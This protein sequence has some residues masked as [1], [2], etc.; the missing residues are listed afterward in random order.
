MQALL[1]WQPPLPSVCVDQ[2]SLDYADLLYY[3]L[4]TSMRMF[5]AIIVSLCFT[6]SFATLAAKNRRAE[7]ILIPMLDVLQSVPVLGFLSFTLTFFFGLFPASV[8]GA[9]CASVFAIFASQAWNM[10]FS[11]YQSLR[12]VPQDLDEVAR[13]LHL[14]A[15]QRFWKLET[16]FA[17]PALIWNTMMSMSGGWFFVVASEAISVGDTTIKL[18]DIDLYF[19]VAI[20]EKRVDAVSAAVVMMLL[21]IILHDQ[22]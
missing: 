11:F 13:A 15:W 21:V 10:A 18:P 16:P 7:M 12:T 2:L 6:F 1:V 9:E 4:R 19:A 8:L 20:D 5:A 14:S 3:A 22:F 17:M